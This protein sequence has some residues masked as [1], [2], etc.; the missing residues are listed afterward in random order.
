MYKYLSSI[1]NI[2]PYVFSLV[3]FLKILRE[4]I[5]TFV[6]KGNLEHLNR[7]FNKN[8]PTTKLKVSMLD[9]PDDRFI[10]F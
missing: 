6:P 10:D 9:N 5:E 4:P 3:R 2:F 8:Y 7:H 1:N